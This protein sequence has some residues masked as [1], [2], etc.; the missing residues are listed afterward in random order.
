VLLAAVGDNPE[1]IRSEAAFAA[2]CGESRL[3]ACAGNSR[4][5]RLNRGGNGQANANP[6]RIAVV[7]LRWYEQIRAYAERRKAEGFSNKD[8]LRCLKRFFARE[9][10]D[11]L[12]GK[13]PRKTTA[14]CTVQRS[15]TQA[16]IRS[17]DRHQRRSGDQIDQSRPL[18]LG[19]AT[20]NYAQWLVDDL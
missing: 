18:R 5:H 12:M 2:I 11:L 14:T 16:H 9:A 4:H 1:R 17:P 15:A 8:I 7:M 3:Q 6:H 20:K 19:N 10:F 13:P